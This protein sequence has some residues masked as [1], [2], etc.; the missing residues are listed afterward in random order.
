MRTILPA[1]PVWGLAAA[2]CPA[3]ELSFGR[4]PGTTGKLAEPWHPA[5]LPV[6]ATLA[7]S[8]YFGSRCKPRVS[9]FPTGHRT[10]HDFSLIGRVILPFGACAFHFYYN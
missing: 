9:P 10:A 2:V 8:V 7:C 4:M 3:L 1:T 5:G 6:S